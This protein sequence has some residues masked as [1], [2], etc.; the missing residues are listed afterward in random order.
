M[1]QKFLLSTQILPAVF[2]FHVH[3]FREN[4]LLPLGPPS[5]MGRCRR[6]V[7]ASHRTGAAPPV[8]AR[9]PV[10]AHRAPLT[11]RKPSDLLGAT[12]GGAFVTPGWPWAGG[13]GSCTVRSQTVPEVTEGAPCDQEERSEGRGT[14]GREEQV[15][16]PQM[17]TAPAGGSRVTSP[18]PVSSPVVPERRSLRRE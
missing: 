14:E 5:S 16:V 9:R 8:P 3:L 6:L 1:T 4:L 15:A 11:L 13:P 10:P 7:L 12:P 18:G 17:Q 2:V